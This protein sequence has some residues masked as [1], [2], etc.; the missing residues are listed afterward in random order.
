MVRFLTDV[1]SR[2]ALRCINSIE[3]PTLGRSAALPR[4]RPFLQ[5]SRRTL[6]HDHDIPTPAEP[7]LDGGASPQTSDPRWESF[8]KSF[9]FPK[10]TA[11]G[12]FRPGL[13][14]TIHGFLGKRRDKG[15]AL[16]FCHVQLGTQNV[17]VV[18]S[19]QEEGSL[20]HN[21][22]QELKAIPAYSPVCVAGTLQETGKSD[23]V[24]AGKTWDLKLRSVQ[25]LNP[26]PKD[27]IVSKD[28]VWP[29]KSRHLQLRFDPLLQDRLRLRALV[30]ARL[31]KALRSQK[32]T[33]I[34]TPVL[35]KSTP[36]GAREFLVPTRRQGYAYAL[37]QSPQQ[38][39]QVLMAAGIPRYFQFAKCF[40]DED[41][42]ADR[43][44]EF[45]QLDLEMAFASGQ[46]VMKVVERLMNSV[47][48]ML[49][50]DF[51][52]TDFNGTI[53]PVRKGTSDEP[54]HRMD[55]AG[56]TTDKDTPD[57]VPGFQ[58][59][60]PPYSRWSYD[61]AMSVTGSDKPDLRIQP[62]HASNI[63]RVE[64]LLSKDFV[65]MITRLEDPIVEAC[66]FRLEGS[67]HDNGA[68]I[69][70]FFD[71]LRNTPQKLGADSTPGVF[72]FDSS[73][74]LQGL[75]ALGH[76]GAEGLASIDEQYWQQCEDGDIIMIHARKN[77]PFRGGSTEL[78]KIRKMI[79]DT[80]VEKGCLPKD[81]SFKF[82]WVHDFPLFS[83]TEDDPGQGGAAGFSSTHHPFTAPLTPEDLDLLKTDPLRARADH[84]D[85]VLNGVELGG[86]SRRI[87]VAEVQEYIMRDILKMTDQGVG[88]FAHLIEA[89]R[90]GCPPHAGFAF[91]FDRL[92]AVICDVPS[93]KDVIAFPKSNKGE[94]LLV[95]S[96]TKTTPEQQKTY[97][98]F[99]KS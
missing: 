61:Y 37:P 67:P 57:A 68:F 45:T 42:R 60:K 43:Q 13:D 65:S 52:P 64:H 80:A 22:H 84:Y 59:A 39:K 76:E 17:Q 1:L 81:H 19:W 16:T 56:N 15:S 96:P 89:L 44:P 78:G 77:E 90:A 10:A 40:R 83:P 27:I 88:Q 94:D 55:V 7:K 74:P 9:E 25:C 72:I 71:N 12:N 34:E 92:M 73:K 75:S 48:E 70:D 20:Q 99:Q 32:F 86:G 6:H 33:Q 54:K 41:H 98:L 46:H 53:H 62:P 58:K 66:K 87:H 18:S 93:V 47:F 79:Y 8:K 3:G 31:S 2:D 95:G 14:V 38:Y 36:E 30:A 63:Y 11:L 26:F 69:R 49:H 29:P 28:A 97:H 21:A 82:L 24:N 91:G 35:F 51:V 23:N 5:Q 50:E 85:L 4:H